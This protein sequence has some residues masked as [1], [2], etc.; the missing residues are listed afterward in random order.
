M[1]GMTMD[2]DMSKIAEEIVMQTKENQYEFIIETIFPFCEDVLQIKINKEKLKQILLNNIQKPQ[3]CED[4]ISREAVREL[5]CQ[6]NDKYGYSDRFHEFTEKCL[7]LPPV[8]PKLQEWLSSFNTESATE[9]FTAVQ[10]L[11]KEVENGR[12]GKE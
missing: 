5:I 1:K 8:T 9:C 2:F 10:E 11:K 12:I 3:S 7:Q 6:D 4:C